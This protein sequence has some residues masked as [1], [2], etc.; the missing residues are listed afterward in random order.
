MIQKRMI[1]VVLAVIVALLV[2]LGIWHPWN[3]KE[4]NPDSIG[5][6]DAQNSEIESSNKDGSPQGNVNILEDEGDI[7][8]EIPEDQEDGGF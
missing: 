2:F 5:L 6:S 3:T 8:I 4:E 1:K 7:T